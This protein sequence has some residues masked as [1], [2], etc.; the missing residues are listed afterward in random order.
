MSIQAY[1]PSVN[2]ELS[3]FLLKVTRK[4]YLLFD[5]LKFSILFLVY[6]CLFRYVIKF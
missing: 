2:N 3:I 4:L 1:I 6:L 5:L